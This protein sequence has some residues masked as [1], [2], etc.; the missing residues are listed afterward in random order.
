MNLR[1]PRSSSLYVVVRL[2]VV[3]LSVT[4]V[5]PTQTIAIFRNV[6]MPFGTLAISDLSIKI[7]RRSS[8]G[9]PFVGGRGG[10]GLNARGIA[11]YSDFWPYISAISQKRCK[12][13]G[14]LLLITNRKSHMG[15][16]LVPKSVILN[17]FERS[18]GGCHALFHGIRLLSGCIT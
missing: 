2:S 13:G 1:S 12:I 15:F 3:C 11:K 6:S 10:W 16:W 8:Q 14:K 7:F 5:H 18:N 17:D 4:F 9:N